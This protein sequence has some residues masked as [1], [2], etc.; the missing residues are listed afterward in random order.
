MRRRNEVQLGILANAAVHSTCHIGNSASVGNVQGGI[1]VCS[2]APQILLLKTDNLLALFRN[3][4][5]SSGQINWGRRNTC[6]A[7]VADT[8]GGRRE[9]G[10]AD[11]VGLARQAFGS[12]SRRR[13]EGADASARITL[14]VVHN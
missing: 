6:P 13:S 4:P 2:A 5:T 14:A 3:K 10:V 11:L 9:V 1:A 8:L 12:R 7:A